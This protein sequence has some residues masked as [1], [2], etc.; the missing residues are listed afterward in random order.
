VRAFG[1]RRVT[2]G[3]IGDESYFD[4]RRVVS[5]WKPSYLVEESPPLSALIVDRGRYGRGIAANPA[6]VA[7]QLFRIELRAAGI[8]VGAGARVGTTPAADFPLAFVH[9]PA[10]NE[11]VTYMGVE[12]DNFIAEMLLKQLGAQ[13]GGPGTSARGAAATTAVLRV[14]GVPLGGVRL[15]DGSGL[16]L[17][18]RL[19]ATSLVSLLQIAWTDPA[20]R[21]LFVRVLP[22]AGVSGT[23]KRRLAPVRGRVQAKTGTT[24]TAST[25]A[26]YV[27]GRYAFAI[28]HNGRPVSTTWARRAQDRFVLVLA[29]G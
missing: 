11:L 4:S 26:G 18:N 19:T 7:A 22:V 1:I 20:V 8:A 10:L 23:M 27:T 9:S 25:L 15:V 12:S 2:G 6:L 21:P 5:G 16:S 24:D 29:A 17:L 3:V 28:L 13:N 14:L